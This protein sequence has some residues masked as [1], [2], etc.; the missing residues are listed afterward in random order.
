MEFRG[1]H[2]ED[3]PFARA[4]FSDPRL[5]WIWLFARVYIGYQWITSGWGK[6]NNP[7]WMDSGD[8]L[9]GFFERIVVIPETG[10]PAITFD[11]YRTF[12][13]TL[14]DTESYTWFAKVIVVGELVVGLALILG[15]FV[16]IA[17]VLGGVMNFNFMLAG[18]AS[19]NPVMFGLAVL[20]IMAWKTAGYYGLDYYLLRFLGT[21]WEREAK[22]S[23]P[24]MKMTGGTSPST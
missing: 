6:F 13:Q 18:S 19:S 11:W 1:R 2:I 20:L 17:A 9:K 22:G 23:P 24:E 7:A 16:G 21:P 10:R 3:P 12:I 4:L 5:A 8:A 15:A 14:I